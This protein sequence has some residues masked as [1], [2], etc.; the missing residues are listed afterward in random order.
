MRETLILNNG[1]IPLAPAG[2][3]IAARLRGDMNRLKGEFYDLELGKVDYGAMRLSEEYRQYTANTALLRNFALTELVQREEKLAFWINLYNTLVIHGIIELDIKESVREI[4][5]FFGRFSYEIDGLTFTPND[6]EHGILR[7]NRHPPHR[8]F[9]P[10]SGS[11]PRH[12]YI[13]YPPDPRIHFALVCGST[14]CPPINF[15]QAEKINDQMDIAASGFINGPEVE[16]LPDSNLLRLSPIFKWY[17]PDFGGRKGIVDF[18]IKYRQA[19]KDR[20]FL[21]E[22]GM[23]ADIEWKEY[24]WRLNG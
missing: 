2:L 12:S 17:A 3:D 7:G 6:I 19:G 14:S 20:D 11:D 10:F 1:P 8:L 18:L 22:Y 24:D 16:I 15:Y 4:T 23:T 21:N 13:I 9:R 5:G